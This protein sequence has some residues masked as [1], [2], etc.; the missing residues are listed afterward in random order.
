MVFPGRHH[1]PAGGAPDGEP[2]VL[3]QAGGAEHVDTH[4]G[5]QMVN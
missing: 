3:R 4:G 5:E 2:E 1:P